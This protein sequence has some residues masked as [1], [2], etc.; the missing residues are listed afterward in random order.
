MIL[1]QKENT[2]AFNVYFSNEEWRSQHLGLF[3]IFYLG[4]FLGAGSERDELLKQ[5]KV[6]YGIQDMEQVF[7]KKIQEDQT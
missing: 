4:R 7:V 2:A 5:V 3:V 1:E 6:E